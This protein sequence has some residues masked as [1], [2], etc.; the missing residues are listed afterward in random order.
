MLK[1]AK[2]QKN[3]SEKRQ[4]T[5]MFCDLVGSTEISKNLDPEDFHDL[6]RSYQN[7]CEHEVSKYSGYIAQYL[8]DG[9]LIYFGYP[10]AREDDAQRAVKAALNIV[11]SIKDLNLI[12]GNLAIAL[13][14]RIGIHTGTVLISELGKER[15][16]EI[17]ALGETPNIAATIQKMA[18]PGEVVISAETLNLVEGYFNYD[19]VS[20]K[21]GNQAS[22]TKTYRILSEREISTRFVSV[23]SKGLTRFIGR[24]RELRVLHNVWEKVKEGKNATVIIGG[25]PGIGKSRLLHE[26]KTSILND[27][28]IMLESQCWEIRKSS[29]YTPIRDLL[30]RLMG[31]NQNESLEAKFT[32]LATFLNTHNFNLKRDLPYFTN[33]LALPLPDGYEIPVAMPEKLKSDTIALLFKLII[34]MSENTSLV[35]IIEDLHWIDPSTLEYINHFIKQLPTTRGVLFLLSHRPDFKQSWGGD[36]VTKLELEKLDQLSTEKMVKSLIKSG[37]VDDDTV[38]LISSKSEGVP[39][40]IEE[41][42][43]YQQIQ[44]GKTPMTLNDS[45]MARLDNL[46]DAK[47]LIQAA[48]VIGREFKCDIL[49]Q[50]LGSNEDDFEKKL[51]RVLASELV[52]T[53]NNDSRNE[54]IFKHSLIQD[55]AYDSLTRTRRKSYHAKVATVLETNLPV[56][57]ETQPGVLA[58]HYHQAGFAEKAISYYLKSGAMLFSWGAMEE[59]IQHLNNGLEL[60]RTLPPT[61][62]R[63]ELELET[64]SK[65]ISPVYSLYS[66]QGTSLLIICDD[67]IGLSERLQDFE[68]ACGA[69]LMLV[70][71]YLTLGEESEARKILSK[72]KEFSS[73]GKALDPVIKFH[74]ITAVISF[75]YEDTSMAE[76]HW[77]K[78]IRIY[79]NLNYSNKS[80]YLDGGILCLSEFS[81]GRTISGFPD[82]ALCRI[83]KS[84]ELAEMSKDPL[85]LPWS[86]QM[87]A[88]ILSYIEDYQSTKNTINSALHISKE[89]GTAIYYYYSEIVWHWLN[90]MEPNQTKDSWLRLND[91]IDKLKLFPNMVK[92]LYMKWII[93]ACINFGKCDS[94]LELTDEII[95]EARSLSHN[96]FNLSELYTLR[97]NINLK[98]NPGNYDKAEEYFKEA[99]IHA[100]NR[101][102]KLLEL[103]AIMSYSHLQREQGKRDE[104]RNM[105]SDIYGRFTEG[106]ET[107][108]L[109]DARKLLAELSN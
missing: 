51:E 25:E 21:S 108:P 101:K 35:F 2:P 106:F 34:K 56:M 11:D 31:Y 60:V 85:L 72:M 50:V 103:K 3:I 89:R 100:R 67:I 38:D 23:L 93:E 81:L 71:S 68:E 19:A 15:R 47:E 52:L 33:V 49:K 32:K 76:E 24:S 109:K 95:L 80:K 48:S 102:L 78:G 30:E 62:Q 82:E 10:S 65:M 58:Y 28:H 66:F 29:A 79:E 55:V 41:L 54:C 77:K 8:G 73:K 22:I 45:L 14:V 12:F 90:S 42:A 59:S 40:F 9:V 84:I 13:N 91:A 86:L 99:I 16:R 97:G 53:M 20:T 63:D 1:T 94:A 98:L 64:L 39:L 17:I 70:Y 92:P 6:I 46:G 57:M 27:R 7:V 26:F 43:K 74:S 69:L 96:Y 61:R 37:N 105:L 4:I 75:L 83:N 88:I 107:K 5:V 87:K 104:A 18:N 36:R 44:S